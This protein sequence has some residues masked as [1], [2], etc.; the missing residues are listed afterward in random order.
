VSGKERRWRN[1]WGRWP[2]LVALGVALARPPVAAADPPAK[3]ACVHGA[4]EGQRLRAQGKLREAREA[5]TAC[6]A[7]RCPALVRSDCSGWL[8]E[9]EAALPTVVVRASAAE[10]PGRELYDVE[11]RVDGVVLTDRLDGR[12]LAV[13]PGEHHFSFAAAGR[14]PAEDDVVIRAGE[15][16][17]L[18]TVTLPSTHPPPPPPVVV[19]PAPPPPPRVGTAAKVLLVAGGVGLAGA[20]GF[21]LSGWL[22][23]RSLRRTCA[24]D[25]PAADVDSVRTRLRIADV[26]LAVGVA[27]L[28]AAGLVIWTR[29]DFSAAAVGVAPLAGGAMVAVRFGSPPS[30]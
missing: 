19:K 15:K 22:E 27:A 10:T 11:V 7:E 25:C 1:P 16:H 21:G 26:S 24:P 18:L 12:E 8:A 6:A 2:V 5:F 9:T 30:Y 3:V 14:V 20:A 28:A 13:N 4:E 17:R 29:P 23:A